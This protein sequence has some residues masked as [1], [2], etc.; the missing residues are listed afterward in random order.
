N[1]ATFF[2]ATLAS[3]NAVSASAPVSASAFISA[4]TAAILADNDNLLAFK[5]A[6]SASLLIFTL[7]I[8]FS[9]F[10]GTLKKII[11]LNSGVSAA[12]TDVIVTTAASSVG[13]IKYLF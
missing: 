1:N 4:L 2:A 11:F 13:S 9:A 7:V 6:A 12:F 10:M 5:L 8:G 3:A